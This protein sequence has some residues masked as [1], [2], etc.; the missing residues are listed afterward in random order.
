MTCSPKSRSGRVALRAMAHAR[1]GRSSTIATANRSCSRAIRISA[2]RASLLDV[3][4]VDHRQPPAPQPPAGD[5]VQDGERVLGRALVVRVVGHQPAAE[6][7]RDDLGGQEVLRG[8]RPLAGARGADQHHQARLRKLDPHRSNTAI[9]VGGPTSASSGPTGRNRTVVAV[10]GRDPLRPRRELRARPLEAVVRVAERA[11]R[12]RL[13]HAVVLRV[14]R[15]HDDAGRL[16]RAEHVGLERLQPRRVEVL[17]HLDQ[18]GR[19]V[20]LQALVAIG[21]RAVQERDARSG[22]RSRCSRRAACSSARGETST[23]VICS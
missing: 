3:G 10:L 13:P 6:V 23:P 12:Q 19:V 18:R 9:C 5:L 21:Q 20:A 4:G 1:S 17:D 22:R 15:R 7:R 2:A 16:R 11:R 14:R 8:E